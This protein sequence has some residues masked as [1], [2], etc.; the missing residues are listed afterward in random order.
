MQKEAI[1]KVPGNISTSPPHPSSR[2]VFI[3]DIAYFR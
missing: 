1:L 2:N 3:K